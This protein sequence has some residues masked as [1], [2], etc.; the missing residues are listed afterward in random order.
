MPEIAFHSD[1]IVAFDGLFPIALC[2]TIINTYRNEW[3]TISHYNEYEA[4]F[5]FNQE[6][7]QGNP[8]RGKINNEIP[9]Y[10]AK[11]IESYYSIY[12]DMKVTQNVECKLTRYTKGYFATK[13]WDYFEGRNMPAPKIS[14]SILLNDSYKGGELAFHLGNNEI[15]IPNKAG[16]VVLWPSERKYIHEVK[17]IR[18][19]TRY[20]LVAWFL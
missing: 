2:K 16:R 12:S 14:C 1:K 5:L 3:D 6:V 11:A 20:S 7:A 19:G 4:I 9:Q 18:K 15:K 17:K 10:Y 8:A 13:H